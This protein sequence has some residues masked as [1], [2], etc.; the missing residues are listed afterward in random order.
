MQDGAKR[1]IENYNSYKTLKRCFGH[2]YNTPDSQIIEELDSSTLDEIW[3]G[4][5][6]KSD[7]DINTQEFDAIDLDFNIHDFVEPGYIKAKIT[8]LEGGI[9]DPDGYAPP[10]A[11]YNRNI[12]EC[13]YAVE[14]YN[15][16]SENEELYGDLADQYTDGSGPGIPRISTRNLAPG[17][18]DVT[19]FRKQEKWSWKLERVNGYMGVEI[20]ENSNKDI[21]GPVL[22]DPVK[23]LP[24]R[25]WVDN[26]GNE[27]RRYYELPGTPLDEKSFK[28][29]IHGTEM[30]QP[31]IRKTDVS[32][33]NPFAWYGDEDHLDYKEDWEKKAKGQVLDNW[34]N[35]YYD[36]SMD[37]NLLMSINP[38][39]GNNW[40]PI[41]GLGNWGGG[42]YGLPIVR[43]R[44]AGGIGI[45]HLFGHSHGFHVNQ[46]ALWDGRDGNKKKWIYNN[47]RY[48]TPIG[49]SKS[50][51]GGIYW[52]LPV[53]KSWTGTIKPIGVYSQNMK[54][55]TSGHTFTKD[56]KKFKDSPTAYLAY[57]GFDNWSSLGWNIQGDP[58]F[59]KGNGETLL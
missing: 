20:I 51:F 14:A 38:K 57:P 8:C 39:T 21:D 16:G 59:G 9:Q 46:S 47:S 44:D 56:G 48:I 7:K 41:P 26:N 1:E 19:F 36:K 3:D 30:I 34:K 18:S 49:T 2:T 24:N 31:D 15:L 28:K 22:G 55:L 25:S 17:D 5:P 32:K 12:D 37:W 42:V 52:F 27:V 50:L 11:Y 29:S 4:P 35:I 13:Y 45:A 33:F 58:F 23:M 43:I 6:I 40:Q 53:D 54:Y 10:F